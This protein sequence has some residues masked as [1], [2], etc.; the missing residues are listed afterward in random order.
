VHCGYIK[1]ERGDEISKN[2]KKKKVQWAST[3]YETQFISKFGA[4]LSLPC[5]FFSFLNAFNQSLLLLCVL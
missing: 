1:I 5:P 4:K 3:G 2:R